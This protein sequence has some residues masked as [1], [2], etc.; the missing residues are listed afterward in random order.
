LTRHPA[1][2]AH[3]QS[4]REL[5]LNCQSPTV[6]TSTAH[7][8]HTPSSAPTACS[9]MAQRSR[10][11][12]PHQALAMCSIPRRLLRRPMLPPAF[13]SILRRVRQSLTSAKRKAASSTRGKAGL[14]RLLL[15]ASMHER[16]S[17]IEQSFAYR[18]VCRLF[19]TWQLKQY[20]EPELRLPCLTSS[21]WF[22][23][24]QCVI[25]S[26]RQSKRVLF[27]RRASYLCTGH[28]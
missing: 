11:P 13:R 12:I 9:S 7:T 14:S 1:T 2:T 18:E 3:L 4:Q 26:L 24:L 27:F 19:A 10:R 6:P 17:A 20:Q 23:N 15:S 8:G 21:T 5:F 16:A 25:Y 28:S 22:P